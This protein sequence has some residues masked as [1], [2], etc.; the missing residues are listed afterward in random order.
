MYLAT[1]FFFFTHETFIDSM[2][3]GRGE[4][5]WVKSKSGLRLLESPC[6]CGIEPPDS[7]VHGIGLLVDVCRCFKER[8]NSSQEVHLLNYMLLNSLF[9]SVAT[10]QKQEGQLLLF[11]KIFLMLRMPVIICRGSMSAIDILL[12]YTIRW[13][14][15]E[16]E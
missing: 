7:I 9:F 10:P 1:T 2:G 8:T 4:D 15:G 14:C 5:L 12:S 16:K 3:I 11:M 13:V 6:K